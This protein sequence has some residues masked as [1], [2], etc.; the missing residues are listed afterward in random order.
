MA[1]TQVETEA[2]S[3]MHCLLGP[4]GPTEQGGAQLRLGDKRQF[5]MAPGTGALKEPP[6]FFTD[7]PL[8]R[9]PVAHA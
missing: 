9:D 2:I 3:D 6:R 7:L 4:Q 8:P 5:C 1:G